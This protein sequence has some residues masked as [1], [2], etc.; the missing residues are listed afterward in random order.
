MISYWKEDIK[1]IDNQVG[2]RPCY[3][4]TN[5][6]VSSRDNIRDYN[7]EN[8]NG[9]KDRNID[10]DEGDNKVVHNINSGQT[11]NVIRET[12]EALNNN[13][14]EVLLPNSANGSKILN[15]DDRESDEEIEKY[16]DDN[17]VVGNQRGIKNNSKCTQKL[18][19]D[20]IQKKTNKR[21]RINETILSNGNVWKK[22]GKRMKCERKNNIG[23]HEEKDSRDSSKKIM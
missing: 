17:N 18:Q 8:I 3:S 21:K 7:R 20:I 5:I 13:S 10:D 11:Y 19:T 22:D 6:R 4:N 9:E 16:V 1:E 14:T 12:M 15:E 2:K 23:Y